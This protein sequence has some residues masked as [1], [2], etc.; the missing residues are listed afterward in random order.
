MVLFLKIYGDVVE[1]REIMV[2]WEEGR[3][4]MKVVK[5]IV[6]LVKIIKIGGGCML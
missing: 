4:G 6:Y 3:K 2:D 5:I 1:G